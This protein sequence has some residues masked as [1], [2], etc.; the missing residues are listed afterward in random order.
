[1]KELRRVRRAQE[2]SQGELAKRAGI[3]EASVYGIE[4]GNHSPRLA[5]LEALAEAFQKY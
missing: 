5:T 2:L 4:K 1:M 3:S